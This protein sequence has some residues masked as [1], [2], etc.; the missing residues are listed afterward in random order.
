MDDLIIFIIELLA[1]AFK[2]PSAPRAPTSSNPNDLVRQIQAR[3]EAAR[4]QDPR[5]PLPARPGQVRP[6]QVRSGPRL[7]Q[8]RTPG[9][10]QSA[11]FTQ[12]RSKRKLP[13]ALPAA[14]VAPAPTEAVVAQ[15]VAP[16]PPRPA[17]VNV[18]AKVLSRWLRPQTLRA[19]FILTEVFQPPV[20]LRESHLS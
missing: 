18:D 5:A 1:K 9:R 4:L 2:P 6:S 15:P 20:A 11:P 12:K 10:G 14:V 3:I 7:A 19:Q 16:P 17:L 13:P 8:I